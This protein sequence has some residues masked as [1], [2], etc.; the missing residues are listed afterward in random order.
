MAKNTL[1]MKVSVDLG[2][3]TLRT[4]KTINNISVVIE[5]TAHKD[6]V[7]DLHKK[8]LDIDELRKK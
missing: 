4:K 5:T 3:V 1:K 8:H 7:I 6:Y 2:M